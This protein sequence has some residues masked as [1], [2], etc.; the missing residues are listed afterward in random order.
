MSDSPILTLWQLIQGAV[1]TAIVTAAVAAHRRVNGLGSDV[2]LI[3]KTLADQAVTNDK[4]EA[5]FLRIDDAFKKQVEQHFELKA[6]LATIPTRDEMQRMLDA[7]EER[8][9]PR[10]PG[11]RPP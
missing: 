8:L 4:N 6:S 1:A 11:R 5:A 3:Q 9:K 7:F 10:R 2:A